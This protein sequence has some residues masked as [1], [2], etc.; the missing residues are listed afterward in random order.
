MDALGETP[1]PTPSSRDLASW[2]HAGSVETVRGEIP[3]GVAYLVLLD[4]KNQLLKPG[5]GR[6]EVARAKGTR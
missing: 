5:E 4:S 2:L 3:S 1:C 6:A